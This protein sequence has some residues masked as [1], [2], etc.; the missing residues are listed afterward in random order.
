MAGRRKEIVMTA[1]G[2]ENER[3][4]E[5]EEGKREGEREGEREGKREGDL[6][7]HNY[8]LVHACICEC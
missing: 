8:L 7:C 1:V 6:A 3:E 2:R 5:G 4:R